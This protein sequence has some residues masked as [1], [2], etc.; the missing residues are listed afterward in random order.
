MQITNVRVEL[1][2]SPDDP[3]GTQ[4]VHVTYQHDDGPD[5]ELEL[6]ITSEETQ[7]TA[8][9][10]Y[11]DDGEHL[12]LPLERYKRVARRHPGL[13]AILRSAPDQGED[14]GRPKRR[15]MTDEFLT[16]VADAYLT[17]GNISGIS[18]DVDRR[19]HA[20]DSQKYRWVKAARE[21]GFLTDDEGGDHGQH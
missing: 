1:A 6:T 13:A 18:P 10:V 5:V 19:F 7:V 16:A 2:F 15:T 12:R 9:T 4:R 14:F 20:T 21:R 11:S 8:V 17:A 3:T